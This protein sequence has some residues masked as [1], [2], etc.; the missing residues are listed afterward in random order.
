MNR[1]NESNTFVITFFK[2]EEKPDEVSRAST[3][4]LPRKMAA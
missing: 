4:T 3:H 1:A 2:L